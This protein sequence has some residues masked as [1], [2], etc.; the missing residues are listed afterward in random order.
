LSLKEFLFTEAVLSKKFAF[1]KVIIHLCVHMN[2]AHQHSRQ[3]QISR[4]MPECILE[5]NHLPVNSVITNVP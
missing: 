2:H 1:F 3:V 5:R 4:G